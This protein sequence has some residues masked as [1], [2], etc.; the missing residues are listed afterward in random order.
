MSLARSLTSRM[1]ARF[2]DASHPTMPNRTFSTKA[3]P[4]RSHVAEKNIDR[5]L[6][7][8]PVELLSTS[9]AL[10]YEAPDI[11]D[12]IEPKTTPASP[13]RHAPLMSPS[14]TSRSQPQSPRT[15]F[16]P[17]N[18]VSQP[19]TPGL[20][21]VGSP[22][23]STSSASSTRSW[24]DDLAS[25]A[26]TSA[27]SVTSH[28]CSREPSPANCDPHVMSSTFLL[29][30]EVP[31]PTLRLDPV[32]EQ[33]EA[34]VT[35]AAVLPDSP[36]SAGVPAPAIPQ[37]SSTHTKQTH[38]VLARKRS[39]SR[40]NSHASR[41]PR[42]SSDTTTAPVLPAVTR[43]STDFFVSKTSTEL[44][45]VAHSRGNSADHTRESVDALSTPGT[46]H[47][48]KPSIAEHPFGAELAQVKELA[49]EFGRSGDVTVVDE[50]TQYLLD[51]GFGCFGAHDYILEIQPLFYRAY[52]QQPGLEMI[53]EWI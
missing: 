36:H 47:A 6:I 25:P 38:Q 13:G 21:H 11:K 20:E 39:M 10:A 34:D 46:Q 33:K 8:L 30:A 2:E 48:P 40:T 52:G 5:R 3:A 19:A 44:F 23:L 28:E 32:D 51:N 24:D 49:E 42:E 27:S 22:L 14:L 7:S 26:L 29:D 9:N 1:R 16:T 43:S 53:A 31:S 35:V 41:S 12:L 18:T 15:G 4:N 45:D 37:R 50:E 17:L